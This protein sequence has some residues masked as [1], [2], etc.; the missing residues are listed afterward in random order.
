MIKLNEANDVFKRTMDDLVEFSDHDPKLKKAIQWL[1]NEAY[2]RGISFYDMAYKIMLNKSISQDAKHWLDTEVLK[3]WNLDVVNFMVVWK[4]LRKIQD[5]VKNVTRIHGW[6]NE[7]RN[8][9]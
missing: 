5:G 7:K 6:K 1:D 4:K 2:K 9:N 8:W 3:K